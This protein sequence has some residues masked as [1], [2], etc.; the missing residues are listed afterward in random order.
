M[1]S[2]ATAGVGTKLMRW[3]DGAWAEIAEVKSI[4]GPNKTK[5]TIDVT[6][7]SSDG[8]YRET[9]GGFKDAGSVTMSMI[10]RRDTYEIMN[11][12]F[13][14]SGLKN[15]EIVFP[16][17][18]NTTIEFLA[19]VTELGLAVTADEAITAEATL[20]IS[21]RDVMNSGSGSGS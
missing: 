5:G 16:D 13:E 15:Y 9:I 2:Q 10:F 18:E 12:D 4:T 6:S 7:L 8:G 21:G 11:T 14:S 3:D 1:S 17:S 20:K 19:E